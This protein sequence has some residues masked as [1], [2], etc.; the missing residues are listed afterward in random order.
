MKTL[1]SRNLVF[2]RLITSVAIIVV[3]FLALGD[4]TEAARQEPIVNEAAVDGGQV[5][6]SKP[7][8]TLVGSKLHTSG[9]LILKLTD[10]R[11]ERG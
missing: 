4:F 9:S 10:F 8:G 5:Y 6:S 11:R 3:G 1:E 7:T 2:Q